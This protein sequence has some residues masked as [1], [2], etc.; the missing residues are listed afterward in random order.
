MPAGNATKVLARGWMFEINTG[1]VAVPAWVQIK[2]I[3]S[4][5]WSPTK[6]DADT[7]TYESEGSTEHLPASRGMSITFSGFRLEDPADG[8]RDAGQAAVEAAARL[9][10]VAGLK[11]L[12][13]TSPGGLESIASGSWDVNPGGGGNDDPSAWSATFKASGP[14]PAFA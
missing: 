3:N 14:I 8:A 2:G 13:V 6:N 9:I 12:R 10:D 5:S 7:T 4:H 1:T 11:Q